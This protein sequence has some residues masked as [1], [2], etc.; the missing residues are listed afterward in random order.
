MMKHFSGSGR[1]RLACWISQVFMLMLTCAAALQGQT[2]GAKLDG[3]VLDAQ[4]GAV[5]NATITVTNTATGATRTTHTDASGNYALDGLAAGA[6]TV[7]VE[8][9]GFAKFS[10]TGVVLTEG[11]SQHVPLTLNIQSMVQEVTVN[12]G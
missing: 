8:A 9:V 5:A 10:K 6:C 3:T 4:G 2:A 7:E 1:R 12:A 11:Q